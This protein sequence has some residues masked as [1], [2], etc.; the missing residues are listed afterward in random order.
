MAEMLAKGPIAPP[1][2]TIDALSMQQAGWS[3]NLNPPRKVSVSLPNNSTGSDEEL[4]HGTKVSPKEIINEHSK[5]LRSSLKNGMLRSPVS[6]ERVPVDTEQQH[7]QHFPSSEHRVTSSSS[8]LPGSEALEGESQE[9][10]SGKAFADRHDFGA[11]VNAAIAKANATIGSDRSGAWKTVSP[12][13]A[14]PSDSYFAIVPPSSD[15]RIDSQP[16]TEQHD[17]PVDQH[18]DA[19]HHPRHFKSRSFGSRAKR[20][21]SP[22]DEVNLKDNEDGGKPPMDS[23]SYLV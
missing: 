10:T 6:D 8:I 21:I 7:V 12:N 22:A 1:P 23:A 3:K 18:V 14:N 13:P 15:P 20:P 4:T 2:R 5:V 9:R 17:P 19:I 16:S 11:S